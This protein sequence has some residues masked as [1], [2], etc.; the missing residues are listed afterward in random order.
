YPQD[1]LA[2][3]QVR[4]GDHDLPVESARPQQGR[5]EDVGPVGRGDYDHA[6]LG[7]EAVQ[8]DQQLVQR[9]LALVVTATE[10]S[11]AVP[12]DRVDLV[13]EHDRRRVGLGLLEQVAH[14]GGTDTDEHLD[15]V[16]T[17]DGVE[18]HPGL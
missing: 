13:D 9:L 5:V 18:R 4:L 6:A 1:A 12:A 7:V 14:S 10:A 2:A 17:G 16:R 15:E 8:F 3:G 11:A